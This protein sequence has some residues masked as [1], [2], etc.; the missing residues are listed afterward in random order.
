MT[1]KKVLK[2]VCCIVV[3][4]TLVGMLA[5]Q[6]LLLVEARLLAMHQS[7]VMMSAYSCLK[8]KKDISMT[9][10]ILEPPPRVFVNYLVYRRVMFIEAEGVTRMY[11]TLF[12]NELGENFRQK[13]AAYEDEVIKKCHENTFTYYWIVDQELLFHL[14][15]TFLPNGD[16]QRL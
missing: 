11:R 9:M 14:F 12:K 4:G 2:I 7:R 6:R 8:V 5:Y 16:V 10:D 13:I 3:F 15:P 1:S